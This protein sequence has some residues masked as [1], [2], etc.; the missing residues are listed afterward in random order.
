MACIV[1]AYIGMAYIVMA[2]I[3]MAYIVMASERSQ[4]GATLGRPKIDDVVLLRSMSAC[5]EMP[6]YHA[7]LLRVSACSEMPGYHAQSSSGVGILRD[8]AKPKAP[9]AFGPAVAVWPVYQP[10]SAPLSFDGLRN[11][12]YFFFSFR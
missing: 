5:S 1:M 11:F 4:W 9:S 3:V 7:S 10:P 8:V 12:F 2:Y 6:G